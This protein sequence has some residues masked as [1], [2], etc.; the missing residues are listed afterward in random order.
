MKLKTK[1]LIGGLAVATSAIVACSSTTPGGSTHPAPAAGDIGLHLTLADGSTLTA[2]SFQLLTGATVDL[3]GSIPLPAGPFT[4]PYSVPTYEIAPVPPAP[5]GT[6]TIKVFGTSSSGVMCSGISGSFGVQ[7]SVETQVNV[8]VTCTTNADSGSIMVNPIVQYCPTLQTL[9]G[10]SSTPQFA[11]TSLGG[12]V[13]ITAAASG[14]DQ[15]NVTYAWTDNSP[16]VGGLSMQVNA[17]G[18]TSS[19]VVFT[20][21]NAGFGNVTVTTADQATP[22]KYCTDGSAAGDAFCTTAAVGAACGTGGMCA[23]VTCPTSMTS[24]T[25]QFQCGNPAPCTG[26]GTGVEVTGNSP[27]GSCPAGSYNSGTLKDGQNNYCCTNDSTPCTVTINGVVQVTGDGHETSNGTP[28]GTCSVSGDVVVGTDPG[29]F[30]CCGPLA[31]CTATNT[32]NCVQCQGSTGGTCT[33]TEAYF[34]G[35][36]IAL[37]AVTAAGPDNGPNS[38]YACLFNNSCLDSAPAPVGLGT[39]GKECGDNVAPNAFV[40]GTNSAEC[41]SLISCIVGASDGTTPTCATS[42]VATCYCGTDPAASCNGGTA[43]APTPAGVNGTCFNQYAT[44]LGFPVGDGADIHVNYATHG[45]AAGRAGQIFVCGG[46]S[47][48]AQCAF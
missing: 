28:T 41:T 11:T 4:A 8:I 21:V 48:A 2:L 46:G 44:G 9:S 14:P 1:A 45:L 34:V 10:I 12:T 19:Q 17:P 26:V 33:A 32:S 18:G 6:Y 25:I 31:P 42:G 24:Q 22:T 20:C 5:A 39:T 37:G 15:A 30:S 38:C 7:A 3:S 27:T 47:C 35:R 36:D 29:G 23:Q 43:A 16:T 40:N 13:S